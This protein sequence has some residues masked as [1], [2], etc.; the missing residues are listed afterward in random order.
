M[1]SDEVQEPIS[2]AL[3]AGLNGDLVAK[4]TAGPA[5]RRSDFSVATA[6]AAHTTDY[7]WCM[8]DFASEPCQLHRDCINCEEHE[9]I[10][11]EEHK[12]RNLRS[13]KSETELLLKAAK[14]AL[15]E[16]EFGADNWVKH[17]TMTLERVNAQLHI[18]E[19]PEVQVGA[20]VRL[21]LTSATLILDGEVKPIRFVVSD[22]KNLPK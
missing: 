6:A 14:E 3:R 10:K 2:R 13:L 21:N 22:K 5:I 8:H 20:R 17:Q 16:E 9:C 12:E 1:S 19:D 18:L 11:G 15:S 7:G 4:E